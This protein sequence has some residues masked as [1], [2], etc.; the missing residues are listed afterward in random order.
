[1]TLIII[2][3][4]EYLLIIVTIGIAVWICMRYRR[5]AAGWKLQADAFQSILNDYENGR[6]K[7]LKL[8]PM[9]DPDKPAAK[10]G[11]KN[12]PAPGPAD[13]PGPDPGNITD[14]V[15]KTAPGPGKAAAK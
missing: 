1:M 11:K 5:T 2:I 15:K 14:Q 12:A 13:Q 10:S 3:I 4:V 9:P 6:Y 8:T 7:Y